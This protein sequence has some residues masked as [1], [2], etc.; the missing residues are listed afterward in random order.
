V[1]KDPTLWPK[2]IAVLAR[3]NE[4]RTRRRISNIFDTGM[5]L[6]FPR[7]PYFRLVCVNRPLLSL[8]L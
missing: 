3:M 7:V 8:L 1:G 4:R 6:L 5:L 2:E